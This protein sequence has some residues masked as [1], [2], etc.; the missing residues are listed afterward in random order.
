MRRVAARSRSTPLTR[1]PSVLELEFRT[2]LVLPF[3]AALPLLVSHYTEGAPTTVLLPL[4]WGAVDLSWAYFGY[5]LILCVGCASSINIFAGLNGLE[6]GQTALLAA[7]TAAHVMLLGGEDSARPSLA[8][9]LPLLGGSLALLKVNA[10]PAAAFVGDSWTYFAGMTFAASAVLG[11]YS[12]TLM[13]LFAPQILNAFL[14]LPMLM[15]VV[16]MPRHRLPRL[17][18]RTGLLYAVP[19]HWNL[20][21]AVLYVTGPMREDRLVTLLL[22][23]QAACLVASLVFRHYVAD[24]YFYRPD[25]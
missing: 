10:Y 11:R 21:N 15:G 22:W 7:A 8:L 4:G 6:A 23:L 14:S 24:L 9:I 17:D 18:E 19:S 13:L 20:V 1:T 2:K 25:F 16:V 3:L 12:K 5:L